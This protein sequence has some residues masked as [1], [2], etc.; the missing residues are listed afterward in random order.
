MR[1]SPRA[2]LV[3]KAHTNFSGQFRAGHQSGGRGDKRPV[4][5]EAHLDGQAAACPGGDLSLGGEVVAYL[6]LA[7]A[8][9]RAHIETTPT[10]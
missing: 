6:A 5:R 3:E 1:L 8:D 7:D 9:L 2:L 4:R 10:S